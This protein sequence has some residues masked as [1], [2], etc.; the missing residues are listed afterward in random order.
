[1]SGVAAT[2]SSSSTDVYFRVTG[3]TGIAAKIPDMTKPGTTTI[4]TLQAF[5]QKK[6]KVPVVHVFVLQGSEGFIPTPDQTLETL[7]GVYA[8]D[9]DGKSVLS[10]AVSTQIFQG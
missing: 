7:R 10:L 9:E 6:L 1:M 2:A 8:F 4:A 5:F 3:K